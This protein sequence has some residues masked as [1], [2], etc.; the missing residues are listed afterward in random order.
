MRP[1]LSMVMGDLGLTS[2]L[3][4][5]PGG[6][7]STGNTSTGGVVSSKDPLAK[8]GISY[9]RIGL[10]TIGNDNSKDIFRIFSP[11]VHNWNGE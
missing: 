1:D 4:A 2:R 8:Q 11:H 10:D 6:K 7:Q 5:A 3:P 9:W